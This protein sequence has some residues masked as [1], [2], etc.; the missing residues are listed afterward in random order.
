MGSDVLVCPVVK[1]GATKVNCYFP[2]S[3]PWYD[4]RTLKAQSV[5]SSKWANVDA[6]IDVIPVYQR[7]GSV[8]P[9]RMRLR[10]STEMMRGDPY[11]LFVA[12]SKGMEAEGRLYVDDGHTYDFQD[13]EVRSGEERS[14][15]A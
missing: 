3:E 8:V 9:K 4:S 7:G 12:P 5:P 15:D 11:T 14:T 6:P 2:G 1:K 10:R 13:G